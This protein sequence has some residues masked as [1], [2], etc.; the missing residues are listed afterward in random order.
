MQGKIITEI[1]AFLIQA[2]FQA[3]RQDPN[4][5]LGES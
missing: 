1:V 2:I 4:I 3:T 5:A